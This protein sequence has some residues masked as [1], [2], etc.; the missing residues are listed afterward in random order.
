MNLSAFPASTSRR[1]ARSWVRLVA[2]PALGLFLLVACGGGGGGPTNPTPPPTQREITYTS[3]S[4]SVANTVSLVQ[5][6]STS[7]SQLTLDLVAT[8]I[9]GL[10]GVAFDLMYPASILSFTGAEERLHLSGPEGEIETTL[11]VADD[12]GTLI[13]GLSRLGQVGGVGGTGVLLTLTF[14]A[15]ATGNGSLVFDRESAVDSR[16]ANLAE[17][18]FI[19]GRLRIQL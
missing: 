14:T 10:Y 5:T 8:D 12:G 9:D 7:S 2:A 18:S 17:V 19:G 11:Q 1:A 15:T 3:D 4:A 13:V 6:S 16:G